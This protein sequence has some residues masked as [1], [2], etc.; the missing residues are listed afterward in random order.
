[1]LIDTFSRSVIGGTA[2][3]NSSG[4]SRFTES[5]EALGRSTCD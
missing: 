3:E 2:R 5:V 1:M 4:I